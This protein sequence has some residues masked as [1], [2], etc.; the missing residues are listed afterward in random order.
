MA[1]IIDSLIVQLG[2]DSSSFVKNAAT[3]R[4]TQKTMTAEEAKAA[5]DAEDFAKK[6]SE[7]YR[8]TCKTSRRSG[9]ISSVLT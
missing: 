3:V 6:R 1:T 2:L 9:A 7:A 8:S 5:K 4:A